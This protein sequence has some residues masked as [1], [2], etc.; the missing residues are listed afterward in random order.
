M[1][2]RFIKLLGFLITYL[3]LCITFVSFVAAETEAAVQFRRI[4]PPQYIAA[5]G[6]SEATSGTGAQMWGLWRKDPG[7]RG[8]LLNKFEALKAAGGIAPA[9]WTFNSND[10]WLEEHGVIMEEPSFPLP[11]TKYVVTGGRQVTAILT[12]YPPDESG[13]QRWELDK[14]AKLSDVTHL[15]CRSA[16]YTPKTP[17]SECSPANAPQDVFP[18]VP[19][20]TLPPVEGCNKQ[21]Y[22]VLFVI[23]EAVQP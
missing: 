20:A 1:K 2:Y 10:W 22:A 11:P 6:D 13:D 14:N 3:A 9:R 5:L 18:L 15:P 21:D 12:I 16:R 7:P 23:G 4:N 8:V 19:G 17:E